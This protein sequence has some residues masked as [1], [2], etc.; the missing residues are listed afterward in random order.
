MFDKAKQQSSSSLN[1]QQQ[2]Q[3]E[4][5]LQPSGIQYCTGVVIENDGEVFHILADGW[6]DV[7]FSLNF[8]TNIFKL[9]KT[10][11]FEIA[12][13]HQLR[14]ETYKAVENWG[15]SLEASDEVTLLE[16]SEEV[17]PTAGDYY[18]DPTL[19]AVFVKLAKT[20]N[21]KVDEKV[22][23]RGK[24]LFSMAKR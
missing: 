1:N 8:E 16:I 11:R 23:A 20:E 24:S 14:L 17:Y 7:T 3:D 2:Y 22:V 6:K 15:N 21:A 10:A 13:S 4:S 9:S 5:K 19:R 12:L 18:S